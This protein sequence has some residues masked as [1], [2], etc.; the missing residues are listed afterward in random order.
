MTRLK[1]A[2][3]ALLPLM[4]SSAW[5][6]EPIVYPAKGQSAE[7]LQKDKGECSAWATK[8][9]GVDPVA[10]AQQQV[11]AQPAE[12]GPHGER[13]RG[14]ARGAAAGAAIGAVAGDAGKGAGIGAVTGGV[15]RGA[16]ERRREQ[17]EEASAQDAQ[18]QA[19]D[20]LATYT[21]AYGACLEGRGYTVK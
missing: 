19:R 18:Q 6:A 7:Q 9:T 4:W 5:A 16:R 17:A 1:N 15:A 13:L 10:I 12:Q 11:D 8:T 14:A 3:V 20:A 21:R 2:L